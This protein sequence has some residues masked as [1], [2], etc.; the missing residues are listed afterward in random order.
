M[1]KTSRKWI[2]GFALIIIAAC[3][4]SRSSLPWVLL[5]M[6]TAPQTEM[7]LS[8]PIYIGS[9]YTVYEFAWSPD[10]RHVM[11]TVGG[12]E[13][14]GSEGWEC[15]DSITYVASA[16]GSQLLHIV[17]ETKYDWAHPAPGLPIPEYR[18]IREEP[19]CPAIGEMAG[20]MSFLE[21]LLSS[22][23]AKLEKEMDISMLY[24][25]R[26]TQQITWSP[27]RCYAALPLE[28]G[29]YEGLFVFEIGS[30]QVYRISKVRGW[31]DD[32]AWSIDG[33]YL[34]YRTYRETLRGFN[35]ET[36]S[37]AYLY[38]SQMREVRL[39]STKG[40]TTDLEWSPD[41][42]KIAFQTLLG[43][44]KYVS[45]EHA[46]YISDSAGLNTKEILA[47]VTIEEF[48]WSRD[49][50]KMAVAIG[51]YHSD[52]EIYIIDLDSEKKVKLYPR[53]EAS[54][55]QQLRNRCYPER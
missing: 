17:G 9:H 54:L 32:L 45:P 19:T 27:D 42:A 36:Q 46:L 23:D 39:L 5:S 4:C 41:G 29:S 22:G 49:G 55:Q 37:R 2:V 30:G 10:S 53:G 3:L 21:A 47:G 24:P 35:V 15:S 7:R 6:A 1:D 26:D 48:S 20:E 50:R 43:K 11:F 34:A 16:D 44:T 12:S 38:D 18:I 52:K 40:N 51:P 13:G 14:G 28:I 31:H 8:G 25:Y 33:P